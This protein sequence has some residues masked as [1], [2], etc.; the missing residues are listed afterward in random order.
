[1]MFSKAN[2]FIQIPSYPILYDLPNFNKFFAF[3]KSTVRMIKFF[4]LH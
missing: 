4:Q 1:M 2:I 3:V